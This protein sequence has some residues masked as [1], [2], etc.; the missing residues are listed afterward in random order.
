[1]N[2]IVKHARATETMIRLDSQPGDLTVTISDDGVGPG[3]PDF[4]YGS[5]NGLRNMRHRMETVRGSFS[6]AP[7]ARNAGTTVI[8]RVPL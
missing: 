2:N 1:L 8:F 6:V 4:S 7:G 5:R 3:A